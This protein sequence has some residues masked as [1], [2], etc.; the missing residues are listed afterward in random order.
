MRLRLSVFRS[1]KKIYGQ[2]IDDQ[3]QK[4][5]VATSDKDI[6][7]AEKKASSKLTKKEKAVLVGEALA[8]YALKKGIKQVS[9]DRGRRPYHGRIKAL[10]EG[11]RKGGLDF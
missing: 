5:L 6:K 8:K 7:L 9:F 10:A 2:I 11:A 1:N 3:K 4:T